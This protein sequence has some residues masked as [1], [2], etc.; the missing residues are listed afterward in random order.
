MSSGG[1][2]LRAVLGAIGWAWLGLGLAQAGVVPPIRPDLTLDTSATVTVS[3]YQLDSTL[4]AAA[5]VTLQSPSRCTTSGTSFYKDVTDCWLPEWN[6]VNLGKSVYVV[7]NGSADPATLV[8]P[9]GT[10]TFPLAPGTANPFLAALT[11]S[12]YSGQCTNFGSGAE[13]D[14][15]PLG[16]ATTL[17]TSASTSV[18]GYEL[19][20]TDCGGIAVIQVGSLKFLLPKDGSATVA[21]NGLPDLWETIYGGSLDPATDIDI[22]PAASSPVGDG[23]S[24]FDE[25]RGFIVSG[26]QTR[27]DPKHK[28]LF[29][30]V[31]NPPDRVTTGT[32]ATRF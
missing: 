32:C 3:L 29:L 10:P 9:A 20:P 23:I 4:P 17:P 28:D 26:T 19:K 7:V 8:P 15:L 6:P 2:V 14:F 25:Y 27:T 18:V 24:T 12:A 21:A 16:P 11:T 13:P 31:V 1:W 5:S 30:H 22:G